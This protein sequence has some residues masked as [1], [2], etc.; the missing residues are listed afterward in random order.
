[1]RHLVIV[2]V[3]MTV[4]YTGAYAPA[5]QT[6][7]QIDKFQVSY[8]H[9]YFSWWW[10]HSRPKHVEKRNKHTKKI[11]IVKT[12]RCTNFS[13]LFLEYKIL[14]V[15]DSSSIHHQE[16][17]TIHT[18]MLHVITSLL[19]ACQQDHHCCVYSEKTPD[20]GQ[21]NCPKH[22][23]FYS[24]NK[25]EKLVHLVGFITRIFHD[26]R[27]N[28]LQVLRKIVHQFGFIYKITHL[29]IFILVVIISPWKWQ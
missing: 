26:A 9:R 16:F 14:H 3:W 17:S 7:I 10:A 20:D 29:C 23:K 15:S 22:V 24:N 1:M 25:F 11:V 5:Y 12:N 6:S 21:R 18:A 13:N 8:R 19:T 4:W 27:S 2:T 28:E